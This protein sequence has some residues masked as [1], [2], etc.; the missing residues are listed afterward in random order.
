MTEQTAPVAAE[1]AAWA[2]VNTPMSVEVLKAFCQEDI[3]RL[4]RINPMLEFSKWE[5][6]G[7]GRYRCAGKNI[8]QETPFQFAVELQVIP[9]VDGL[10]VDY[11]G[12]I[13]SSTHFKIE[14]AE[15]GSKLTI[16]DHYD[17]LNESERHSRL[18]E[19]DKSIVAWAQYLQRYIIDW[20][21]W[22]R[23]GLWRW[24]MRRVW[25]PMKPMARRITYILLWI[26]V[27]EIALIMLGAA[28]YFFEY[29]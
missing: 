5:K 16:V 23:F 25:Q 27:V 11:T 12:G 3:E 26:T 21:R 14:P 13:K 8:S 17:G 19:V 4:F 10:Q 24:Y 1:D 29:T 2:S 20:Q 18:G 15:S 22:S 28:I 7:E 9:R 6:L